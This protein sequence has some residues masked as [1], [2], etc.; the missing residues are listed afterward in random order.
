MLNSIPS[1]S[2]AWLI[3][4]VVFGVF[5]FRATRNYQ[6]LHNPLSKLFAYS[7]A[8]ASLAFFFWSVPFIFS[9]DSNYLIIINIIGDFFLYLM[10]VLQA[11]VLHYI[12]FKSKSTLKFILIPTILIASI[13]FVSNCYGYIKN[14]VA[15]I[16]NTFEYNLPVVS[17]I[18]QAILLVIVF[19]VGIVLLTRVFQ[20]TTLRAKTSLV[21][22][23]ILYILSS[24][25]GGLNVLL[26]GSSNQSPIIIIS[27]I[28]GFLIFISIL[29]IVRLFKK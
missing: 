1:N 7:G 21:G 27:Y 29:L 18:A 4:S 12:T 6:R 8:C 2:Y 19:L 10:F 11:V 26:S 17:N 3:G 16:D 9:Y 23:A 14:G 5:A 13:G 20:Q 25:A 15:V 22:I 28:G 24:I